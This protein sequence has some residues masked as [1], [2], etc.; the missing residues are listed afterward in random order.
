MV[1]PAVVIQTSF[2]GAGGVLGTP[3]WTAA[4]TN[5]C[6]QLEDV[7]QSDCRVRP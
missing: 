3:K 6:I 7:L 4:L 2:S 1:P 5:D